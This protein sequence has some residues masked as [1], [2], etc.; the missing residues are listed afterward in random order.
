MRDFALGLAA[1]ADPVGY[2]G[3]LLAAIDNGISFISPRTYKQDSGLSPLIGRPIALV[4]A[5]LKLDLIG[6]PAMDQGMTVVFSAA[7]G[8]DDVLD[9]VGQVPQL[10]VPVRLGASLPTSTMA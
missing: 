9:R 4:R 6:L 10:R 5:A 2:L 8:G 3:E 1:S 7:I